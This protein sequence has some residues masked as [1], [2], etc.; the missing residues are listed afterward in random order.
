MHLIVFLICNSFIFGLKILSIW[1][2]LSPELHCAKTQ[3]VWCIKQLLIYRTIQLPL[4]VTPK[5][6]R[7][8]HQGLPRAQ[9][10]PGLLAGDCGMQ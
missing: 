7:N 8:P 2:K 1:S 4:I 3:A 9:Q 6:Y 5:G 10:G